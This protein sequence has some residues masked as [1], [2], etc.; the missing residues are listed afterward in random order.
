MRIPLAFPTKWLLLAALGA[1]LVAG[2]L[3]Q[4]L[5]FASAVASS[6]SRPALL[7]DAKWGTP[8][9]SFRQRFGNGT[10]EDDLVRWLSENDIELDGTNRASR[11]VRSL[12]CNELIEISWAAT[13]GVIR[14]SNAVVREAGCV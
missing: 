10:P 5:F 2:F 12:P 1:L 14:E 7:R 6:E 11:R 3:W 4:N 8:V 13:D 9:S